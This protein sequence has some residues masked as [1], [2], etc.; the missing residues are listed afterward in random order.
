MQCV[1]CR[2]EAL[3]QE[4]DNPKNIFCSTKCQSKAYN[5]KSIDEKFYNNQSLDV[6][7]NETKDEYKNC[8]VRALN[9]IEMAYSDEPSF[10]Q[11]VTEIK[12]NTRKAEESKIKQSFLN[13]LENNK[14]QIGE[15]KGFY[16][17]TKPYEMENSQK[18]KLNSPEDCSLN[19]GTYVDEENLA[20]IFKDPD[21]IKKNYAKFF[22]VKTKKYLWSKGSGKLNI[23]NVMTYLKNNRDIKYIMLDAAGGVGLA[24]LYQQYGF[25]ILFSGYQKNLFD[26]EWFPS[27]NYLMIGEINDIITKT[28]Q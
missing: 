21:T 28:K 15:I 13:I 17:V 6:M 9:V 1:R 27:L 11:L 22:D 12:F 10:E 7:C 24:N 23:Y 14:S 25:H 4:S 20:R 19:V 18:C 3:F 8:N 2:K 5:L 16:N 26:G